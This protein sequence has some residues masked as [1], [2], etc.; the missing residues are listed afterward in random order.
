[1]AFLCGIIAHHAGKE[2]V[3]KYI[4]A[5]LLGAA[6]YVVLYLGKSFLESYLVMGIAL[7]VVW[8][9]IAQKGVVSIVNGIIAAVVSVPL[10]LALRSSLQK[11]HLL[12]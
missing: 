5:A 1:M 10:Y 2:K 9:T 6:L 12:P 7:D 8:V 3:W 4:L 11:F